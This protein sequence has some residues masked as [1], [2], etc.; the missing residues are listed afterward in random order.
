MKAV[1]NIDRLYTIRLS[2]SIREGSFPAERLRDLAAQ[3]YLQEKWPSHIAN[4]YLQL[5]EQALAQHDVVNYVISIIK[6][7]NLGVGSRG[8]PHA[9]LARQFAYFTG[10]TKAELQR[11]KP[12]VEN[13]ALMEWD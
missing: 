3:F 9:E 6:A 4:V 1:F 7:E 13:R 2:A 12:T 8:V 11:T 10:L 5:D